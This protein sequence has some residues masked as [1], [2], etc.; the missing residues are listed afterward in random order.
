LLVSW[1]ASD[2]CNITDNDEDHGMSRRPG[3]EDWEW[4]STDR[5]LSGRTI[6]RLGDAMC[7]LHHAQGDEECMFLG[8]TSKPRSTVSSGLT[9]KSVA[10][11]FSVWVSK[12]VATI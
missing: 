11:G 9:S 1:C 8:L 3:A 4:S 2:K 6:E 10:S 5:V 12:P 7:D